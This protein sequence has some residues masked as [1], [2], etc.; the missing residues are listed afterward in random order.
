MQLV[1][2]SHTILHH[3]YVLNKCVTQEQEI[4]ITGEDS[5][6]GP[7]VTADRLVHYNFDILKDEDHGSD[8]LLSMVGNQN[9]YGVS[10]ICVCTS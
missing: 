6:D 3:Q 10:V 9:N 5:M 1:Y 2:Q 7:T 8:I 4:S